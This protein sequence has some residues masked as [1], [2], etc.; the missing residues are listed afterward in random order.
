[1]LAITFVLGAILGLI[2][3]AFH[4]PKPLCISL[5][6]VLVF[7]AGWCWVRP[8]KASL[9]KM[10]FQVILPLQVI[11]VWFV[12]ASTLFASVYKVDHAGWLWCRLTG[13]DIATMEVQTLPT[14]VSEFAFQHGL[15]SIDPQKPN[16]LVV[17]KGEY[18]IDKTIV[19]PPNTSLRIEPG[20]T[21]RFGAGCSLISY[22]PIVASGTEVE[23]IVFRARNRWLKWGVVGIVSTGASE[24]KHVCFRDGRRAVV[25]NIS[26]PG[27]LSLIDSDADIC[28]SQF[29]DLFGKDAL[30]VHRGHLTLRYSEFR[31]VNKDGVDLD[32]GTG[33]ISHNNF[34]NCRDE[35]ID[36]SG[37]EHVAV[38]HN[39]V[40][41]PK[42]G[43]VAADHG[44]DEMNSLN[45]LGYSDNE[46]A[47]Y[48]TSSCRMCQNGNE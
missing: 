32:S 23:P 30:Y 24:F 14:S 5:G 37:P 36:L 34:I 33:E 13:Y 40:L 46:S 48:S 31:N 18:N 25:N 17:L 21:F 2:G 26:F 44:L 6:S 45:H 8:R 29:R 41:D 28:N 1:V 35:G 22:S 7:A 15:F 19:V 11:G 47:V 43:R 42:G 27:C 12:S 4:L 38:F 16:C 39:T 3:L 9:A 10:P 20:T